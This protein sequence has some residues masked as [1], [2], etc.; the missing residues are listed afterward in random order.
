MAHS[1]RWTSIRSGI[2][3][4]STQ[5]N[6]WVWEPMPIISTLGGGNSAYLGVGIVNN[7]GKPVKHRAK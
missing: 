2:H 3:I 6:C 4:L 7:T 5:V 1:V